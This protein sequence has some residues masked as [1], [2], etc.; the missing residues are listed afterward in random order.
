MLVNISVHQ[1]AKAET[2]FSAAGSTSHVSIEHMQIQQLWW[3]SFSIRCLQMNPGCR[4]EDFFNKS[5]HITKG[6]RDE[7]GAREVLL[8]REWGRVS[9][10]LCCINSAHVAHAP[11]HL[12]GC[13]PA[14]SSNTIKEKAVRNL[15]GTLLTYRPKCGIFQQIPV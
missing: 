9:F 3:L 10:P 7:K 14:P 13:R 4:E 11:C 12:Q 8:C 15:H 1:Q 5:K 2:I 6:G